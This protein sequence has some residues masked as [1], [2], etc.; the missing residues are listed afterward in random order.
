[1]D[2]SIVSDTKWKPCLKLEL[3][4]PDKFTELYKKYILSTTVN[5]P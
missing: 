1:M 5:S 2:Y 3:Y 4:T